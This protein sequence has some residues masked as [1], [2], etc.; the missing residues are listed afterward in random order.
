MEEGKKSSYLIPEYPL[1]L[2]P[3]LA[4]RIGLNEA[5][6][7]QQLHYWIIHRG[8]NGERYGKVR[9]GKRWI[10]NTIDEW[11]ERNFPFLS[12]SAIHRALGNLEDQK[13][14]LSTNKLN[15]YGYD[16]TKWY[17]I[18]YEAVP[19]WDMDIPN[20]DIDVPNQSNGTGQIGMTIPETTIETTSEITSEKNI[21]PQ[22]NGIKKIYIQEIGK[23]TPSKIK[24]FQ[25][26][27]DTYSDKW[28]LEAMDLAVQYNKKSFG[29]IQAILENWKENGRNGA[30]LT[31][32]NV[33]YLEDEFAEFIEE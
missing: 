21:Y 12:R 30:K 8:Q 10:R 14:I 22:N 6:I 3:Q 4:A 28:I 13:L 5:I 19:K 32:E 20:R 15:S 24:R 23:L 26:W 18:D 29:Y 33:D 9:D 16:R 2:L 17:T 27:E 25:K 11:R 7:I 1:I 31:P